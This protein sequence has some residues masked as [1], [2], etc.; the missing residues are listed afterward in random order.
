MPETSEQVISDAQFQALVTRELNRSVTEEETVVLKGSLARW[1]EVLVALRSH[2]ERHIERINQELQIEHQ[3]CM[4]MGPSGKQVWFRNKIPLE[5]RRSASSNFCRKVQVRLALIKSL[6]QQE[7]LVTRSDD[8]G[9][10]RARAKRLAHLCNEIMNAEIAKEGDNDWALVQR[11][12]MAL[13]DSPEEHF[14]ETA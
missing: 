5:R 13:A 7:A 6:R 9:Y 3:R 14:A 2:A 10:W 12:Q 8:M 1:R 4:E 11:I